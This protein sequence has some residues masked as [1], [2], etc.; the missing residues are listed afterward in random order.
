M[1]KPTPRGEL[2]SKQVPEFR[3]Y[4]PTKC[5]INPPQEPDPQELAAPLLG[6]FVP[7]LIEPAIRGRA[8]AK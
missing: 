4:L 6:L 8:N 2:V 5:P 3:V 7:K 1:V